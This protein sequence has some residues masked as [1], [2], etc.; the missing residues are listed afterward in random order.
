MMKG[1]G[2]LSGAFI[3]LRHEQ[4]FL[5]LWTKFKKYGNI[6]FTFLLIFWHLRENKWKEEKVVQ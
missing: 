2:C 5:M 1:I 4:M 3:I 6:N